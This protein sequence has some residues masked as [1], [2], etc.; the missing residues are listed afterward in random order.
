[1]SSKHILIIPVVLRSFYKMACIV[2]SVLK[3]VWNKSCNP[4]LLQNLIVSLLIVLLSLIAETSCEWLV[5]KI[6]KIEHHILL[7]LGPNTR[8]QNLSWPDSDSSF[9]YHY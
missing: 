2:M 1:M 6:N 5:A 3:Q 4:Y 7:L 8:K 9:I